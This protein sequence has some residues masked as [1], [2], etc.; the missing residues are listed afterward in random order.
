MLTKSDNFHKPK[1]LVDL[2]NLL[3]I[4]INHFKKLKLVF[5][6]VFNA[7]ELKKDFTKKISKGKKVEVQ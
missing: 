6:D 4:T 2:Q 1:S 7:I 5:R 3:D